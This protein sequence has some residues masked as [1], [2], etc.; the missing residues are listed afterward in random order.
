MDLSP[1]IKSNY[2]GPF[3]KEVYEDADGVTQLEFLA[4]EDKTHSYRIE[5][6]G[7]AEFERIATSLGIMTDFKVGGCSFPLR[8]KNLAVS[9][10]M[11]FNLVHARVDP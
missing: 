11:L 7:H 4:F 8:M 5:Y 3:L 1:L 2:D 6:N 9:S 10:T